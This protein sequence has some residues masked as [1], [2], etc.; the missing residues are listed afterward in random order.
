MPAPLVAAG[1][2]AAIRGIGKAVL[3][4]AVKRAKKTP[5]KKI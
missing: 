2:G 4:H 3:R 5:N 1:V